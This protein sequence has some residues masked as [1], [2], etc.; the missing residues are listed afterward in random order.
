[1]IIMMRLIVISSVCLVFFSDVWMVVEW[2][3]IG[4]IVMLVGS[5]VVSCGSVVCMWL[6]VLMMFVLGE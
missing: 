1:M 4:V 6:I 2:L 5:D 3:S